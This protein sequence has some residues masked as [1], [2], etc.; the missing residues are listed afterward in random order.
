MMLLDQMI[1]EDYSRRR[2][3]DILTKASL[4]VRTCLGRQITKKK[5]K[6]K[7]SLSIIPLLLLCL[8]LTDHST[9]TMF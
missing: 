8:V 4:D 2:E 9:V 1:K 7:T 5:K 3:L 6:K